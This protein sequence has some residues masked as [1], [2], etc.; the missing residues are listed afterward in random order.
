MAKIRV[1]L[2][3]LGHLDRGQDMVATRSATVM[4]LP[5]LPLGTYRMVADESGVPTSFNLKSLFAA[6]FKPWGFLV[7]AVLAGFNLF[8]SPWYYSQWHPVLGL[9]S[10]LLFAAVFASWVWLGHRPG[11]HQAKRRTVIAVFAG[12]VALAL[13]VGTFIQVRDVANAIA[14]GHAASPADVLEGMQS[15]LRSDRTWFGFSV[16][17]L[18]APTYGTALVRLPPGARDLRLSQGP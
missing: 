16:V 10:W 7:A 17:Y 8:S 15:G 11:P 14:R 13:A 12:V 5:V 4:F 9:G 6:F 1:G 18:P 2:D 3:F